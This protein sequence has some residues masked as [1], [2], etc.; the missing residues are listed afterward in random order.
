MTTEEAGER[1][2]EISPREERTQGQLMAAHGG[3]RKRVLNGTEATCSQR[4]WDKRF[5]RNV[6]RSML[7]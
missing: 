1:E 4:T 7:V 2:N 6:E 3:K 5:L